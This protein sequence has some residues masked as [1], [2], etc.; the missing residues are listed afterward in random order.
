MH[1][2]SDRDT[3]SLDVSLLEPANSERERELRSEA[4]MDVDVGV[5]TVHTLASALLIVNP[6]SRRGARDSRKFAEACS[7]AQIDVRVVETER[8]GHA[9][10]LARELTAS[11]DFDAVFSIGGDGTASEVISGL[12]GTPSAPPV[13]VLGG[14][15]ANILA[16]TLGMPMRP[17]SAIDALVDAVP[18]AVDLGRVADGRR[19]VIGLGVGLDA[20]MIGGASPRLKRRIG[21]A[22]YALSALRA[23][24]RME[25]FAVRVTVD[26]VAHDVETASLLVANFGSVANGLFRFGEGI[27]HDDGVLNACMYSPR[28]HLDAARIA[29]RMLRGTMSCERC[30][31]SLSGSHFL[32]EPLTPRAA[33][34][35]G[36]LFGAT[37]F[38]ITVEPGA[39]RLLVPRSARVM[40]THN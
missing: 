35:D 10:T 26:G 17:A 18:V 1:L 23:G 38:E 6:A 40:R 13:G 29:W 3:T 39:V 21:Y 34:A 33:Q 12:A 24:L 7:R 36:E 37:P 4:S 30:F 8:P 5:P 15:T 22:A 2:N 20:A 11:G 27:R 14:G 32:I 16:R 31:T 19:F 9:T 28:S 25:R